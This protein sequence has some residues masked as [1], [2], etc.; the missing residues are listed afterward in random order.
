MRSEGKERAMKIEREIQ[1]FGLLGFMMKKLQIDR[2]KGRESVLSF[3]VE[4][5]S[6]GRRRIEK[7]D[8]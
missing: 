5:E 3:S 1:C 8:G 6:R 4:R 2:E 7:V